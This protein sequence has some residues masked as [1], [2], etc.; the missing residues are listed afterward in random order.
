MKD[1]KLLPNSAEF[2]K[3]LYE[4]FLFS[5]PKPTEELTPALFL[6]GVTKASPAIIDLS[7]IHI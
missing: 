2:C 3:F 7:L 6:L 1:S 5:R 4:E